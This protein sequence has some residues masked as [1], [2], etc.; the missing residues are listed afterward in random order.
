MPRSYPPNDY[1]KRSHQHASQAAQLI[2]NSP[3][4]TCNNRRRHRSTCS[5]AIPGA[6][7][8]RDNTA[9]HLPASRPQLEM[10]RPAANRFAG[11][12]PGKRRLRGSVDPRPHLASKHFARLHG[13]ST[14]PV[15]GKAAETGEEREPRLM[16]RQDLKAKGAAPGRRIIRS[17]GAITTQGSDHPQQAW[18]GHSTVL[19][20]LHR[21]PE[22]S[23]CALSFS[24]QTTL[25]CRLAFHSASVG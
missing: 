12:L 8:R 13:Y 6:A 10:L 5:V 15:R 17:N 25:D 22:F 18:G 24:T 9:K 4:R 23:E 7:S 14:D 21:G 19:Y 20:R 16:A 11:A 3:R 1:R 2:S